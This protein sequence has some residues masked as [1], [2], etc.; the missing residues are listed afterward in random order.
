MKRLFLLAGLLLL[1]APGAASAA[2]PCGLPDAKPL[3]VEYAGSAVQFRMTLFGRPGIVAAASDVAGAATLRSLGA[4]TVYWHMGLKNAVGSPTAPA[5]PATVEQAANALADKAVRVS[6][7]ERPLIALNELWGVRQPTPW[8]YEMQ[9]YR[10]NV[11]TLARALARR[12][13][14]PVLLVPGRPRAPFLAGEAAAWWRDLAQVALIVREMHFSA[15]YVYRQGP[16]VGAR[17]RRIAMRSAVEGLLGL[18]IPP[19]RLG[20]LL[21]FQSAQGRGGREGLEPREA[22]LEVV[23]QD[24]LAARTVAAELGLGSVWSWGWATFGPEGADPDKPAAACVYLWARDP[25][26]CDGPAMAGPGFNASLTVGQLDLPPGIQCQTGAGPIRTRDVDRLAAVLGSPR[27][28]LTALLGRLVYRREGG[29][30]TVADLEE[31]RARV[32]ARQFGGDAAAYASFLG[33][34]GLDAASARDIL[35]DQLRRQ[36]FEAVA[37]IR[38][39]ISSPEA[40]TERRLQAL[41]R[42][43]V[44]LR[45]VLPDA[46]VF[47]WGAH[48]QQLRV[49]SP[50]VS[51]S[52]PRSALRRGNPVLV[53]GVASSDRAFEQVT[54]YGRAPRAASFT[55][56][57]TVR[58]AADGTWS[59]RLVTRASTYLRALSRSAAS[60]AILVRVRR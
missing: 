35:A 33:Q 47:D 58:V 38:R 15:P 55:P 16:V 1:A 50:S 27:D 7:C 39:A 28:A 17:L 30:V 32:V 14:T 31:A 54:V 60:P 6:G 12:G 26:L 52:A 24:V 4:Q 8:P 41:Q 43:A 48:L 11:L 57:G 46:T 3:W 36:S 10:S 19:E 42:T 37:Q 23:K 2:L 21:G 34:V 22:W 29:P 9:V 13:A 44:C 5:D 56:L 18:G 51:I 59:M 49:A 45:D 40:Y 20:L 25:S 53:R